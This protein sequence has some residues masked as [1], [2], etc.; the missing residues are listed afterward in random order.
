MYLIV[1]QLNLHLTVRWNIQFD[2][3][4]FN[5]QLFSHMNAEK[6]CKTE[7]MCTCPYWLMFLQNIYF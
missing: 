6:T 1:F 4:Y 7:A 5:E 2:K 3:L